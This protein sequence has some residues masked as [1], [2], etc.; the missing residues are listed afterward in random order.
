MSQLL[1]SKEAPSARMR[2]APNETSS[3]A[4]HRGKTHRKQKFRRKLQN[5]KLANDDSTRRKLQSSSYETTSNE[6]KFQRLI[7]ELAKDERKS[8]NNS[9]AMFGSDSPRII[10]KKFRWHALSLS[11][12]PDNKTIG[13]N[14]GSERGEHIYIYTLRNLFEI[15]LNQTEIRL[16]LPF[17]D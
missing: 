7:N 5:I 8:L 1:S 13:K 11:S 3:L 9:L 15:L 10:S 14:S 4:A 6:G 16:Y 2:R 12:K 17:S